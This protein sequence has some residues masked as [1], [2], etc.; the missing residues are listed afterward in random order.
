MAEKPQ[1]GVAFSGGVDSAVCVRLLQEQGFDVTAWHMLTC[2][3]Q[4]DPATVALAEALNV[5]LNVLDF[6]DTFEA[7]VVAPLRFARRSLE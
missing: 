3:D 7:T 4:V 5:P 1:I 2:R 6:R